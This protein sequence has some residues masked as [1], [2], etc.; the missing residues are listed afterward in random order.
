MLNVLDHHHWHSLFKTGT[1]FLK[2]FI[3]YILKIMF[4]CFRFTIIICSTFFI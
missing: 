2:V 3:M 1:T 4:F